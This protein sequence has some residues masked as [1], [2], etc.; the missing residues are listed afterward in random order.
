[1]E[2]KRTTPRKNKTNQ[3]KVKKTTTRER[4]VLIDTNNISIIHVKCGAC[5]SLGTQSSVRFKFPCKPLA[6]IVTFAIETSAQW[7][8]HQHSSRHTLVKFEASISLGIS[9]SDS[10]QVFSASSSHRRPQGQH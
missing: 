9:S 10:F 8:L 6:L 2:Y 5:N 1:M 3:N 4:S 7:Q